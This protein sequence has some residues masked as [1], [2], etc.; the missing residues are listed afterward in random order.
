MHPNVWIQKPLSLN[1]I[2]KD[3][4]HLL[5]GVQYLLATFPHTGL[6]FYIIAFSVNMDLYLE[7]VKPVLQNLLFQPFPIK[8]LFLSRFLFTDILAAL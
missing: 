8:F 5:F 7:S 2:K 4:L 1:F 3:L 6:H